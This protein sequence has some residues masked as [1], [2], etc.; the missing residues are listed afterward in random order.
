MH[1]EIQRVTKRHASTDQ[2]DEMAKYTQLVPCYKLQH[3][4]TES[5]KLIAQHTEVI[6]HRTTETQHRVTATYNLSLCDINT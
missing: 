3:Q 6:V 5:C 2:S 4:L 1:Q